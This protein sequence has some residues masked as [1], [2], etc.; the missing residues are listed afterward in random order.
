MTK[1]YTYTLTINNGAS[2]NAHSYSFDYGNSK[3]ISLKISDKGIT[4]TY[5][6]TV[7]YK[8]IDTD[9]QGIKKGGL[10]N[11]LQEA[12]RRSALIYMLKFGKCIKINAVTL[13]ALKPAGKEVFND[14]VKSYF[15][16]YYLSLSNTIKDIASQ[17]K[18]DSVI[19]RIMKIR[20]S[21][22]DSEISALYAYLLAKSDE[23]ETDRFQHLWMAF[24]G[25]YNTM[26]KYNGIEGDRNCI[27]CFLSETVGQYE[28]LIKKQRDK[29]ERKILLLPKA[30]EATY[31]K[32]SINENKDEIAQ[33]L[34][35]YLSRGLEND[36]QKLDSI[37]NNP[38]A[39]F[40]ADFTYALRCNLF[41]ANKPVLFFSF[42][43]EL[44]YKALLIANSLLEECLDEHL[45]KVFDGTWNK[46]EEE[47]VK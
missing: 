34:R 28:I 17:L 13:K 15:E 37:C 10:L 3:N 26:G 4:I 32:E 6:G 44:E 9:R 33:I 38:Y 12:V 19:N 7:E 42:Q 8:S 22:F 45:H 47:N 27:N 14:D 21:D 11:L 1:K 36:S 31:K 46:T 5:F 24:N 18:E 43:T 20:K 29:I 40:L 39:F 23:K 30:I 41:H 16:L 35:V 2:Q 25:M